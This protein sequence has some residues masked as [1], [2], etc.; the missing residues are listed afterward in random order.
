MTLRPAAVSA[1]APH[2]HAQAPARFGRG[3]RPAV[4][5]AD[6]ALAV[7]DLRL[8]ASGGIFDGYPA[9]TNGAVPAGSAIFFDPSLVAADWT[10]GEVDVSAEATLQLDGAPTGNGITPASSATV[11]MFQT[12]SVAIRATA[13]ADWHIGGVPQVIALGS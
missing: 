5:Q 10:D 3:R 13:L 12:N 9:I 2:R 11:S 1:G 8:D 4:F 6:L 7:A